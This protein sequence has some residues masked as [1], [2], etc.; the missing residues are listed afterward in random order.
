[1]QKITSAHSQ[2]LFNVA[3]TRRIEQLAAG[4]LPTHTLMQRAGLAVARLAMALS[5]H[6]QCIWVACGPGN[7]GGDGFEAAMHLHQ[8]GKRVV[9]TWTGE[10]KNGLPLDAETAHRGAIAKGVN[11]ADE[12]PEEFDFCIDALLGI[13]AVLDPA[14]EGSARILNW[15]Q[16]MRDSE[17]PCLAVDIPSGLNAYTG[18]ASAKDA[19]HSGASCTSN[20]WATARYTISLL[21]LKPGLFTCEGRDSAGEVWFDDLG[22]DIA[23]IPQANEPP[24]AWLL[25]ANSLTLAQRLHAQHKGSFGDVAVLGGE[26]T[27]SNHM[28]GAAL[29]AASAALH[30][31]A[32]RVFVALLGNGVLNVSAAQPELMFRSPEALDL[33]HQ[34]VV[35]GCGGGQAVKAVLPRVLSSTLR[36]VLDADALNAVAND[37][38]LQSLLKA[39]SACGYATVLTPHPLEAA[40]LLQTTTAQIQSDRLKAAAQLAELFHAVIVLKGSGSVIAAPGQTSRINSSGNALLA[41]AGTGDVLA[42]MLGAAIASGLSAFDAAC[43]AVFEHGRLADDWLKTHPNEALTASR[44]AAWV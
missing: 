27:N 21:T 39:R 3:A 16:I 1:M 4:T 30:R 42:G 23:L 20:D 29:L 10:G 34:V 22:V 33:R 14:R 40:R 2:P 41:T 26:S 32:G 13:G 8:W 25:G 44:L 19:M 5:P 43:S 9:V 37:S 6:A 38:A 28:A 12:P 7:N 24:S 18:A 35:C 15:L 36:L 11:F 31:G 17:K